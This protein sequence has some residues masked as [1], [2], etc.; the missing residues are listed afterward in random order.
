MGAQ[1]YCFS[2]FKKLRNPLKGRLSATDVLPKIF[3][4]LIEKCNPRTLQ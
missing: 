1:M 2:Y 3:L 4:Q